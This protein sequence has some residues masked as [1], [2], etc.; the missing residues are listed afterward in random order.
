MEPDAVTDKSG[1]FLVYFK[2]AERKDTMGNVWIHAKC[3]DYCTFG[4]PVNLPLSSFSEEPGSTDTV[5]EVGA[6]QLN[7]PS[8]KFVAN[9]KC[10]G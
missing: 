6:I 2:E 10:E 9:L 5:I 4:F 7:E 3:G 8:E 1:D